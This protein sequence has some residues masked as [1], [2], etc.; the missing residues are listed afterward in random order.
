MVSFN[1]REWIILNLSQNR[2]AKLALMALSDLAGI[3]MGA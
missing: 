2:N 3:G 1:Q